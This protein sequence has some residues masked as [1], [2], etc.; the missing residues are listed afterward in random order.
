MGIFTLIFS[1]DLESVTEN[2]NRAINHCSEPG[3]PQ[4]EMTEENKSHVTAKE[5]KIQTCFCPVVEREDDAL[6][7]TSTYGTTTA[8]LVYPR[9]T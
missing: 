8:L 2:T 6:I 4:L 1:P 5:K 9:V 7:D 3:I